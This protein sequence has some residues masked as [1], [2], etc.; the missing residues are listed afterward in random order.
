M[1]KYEFTSKSLKQLRKL[2][3]NIQFKIINKLDE[4]CSHE[5]LSANANIEHLTNFKIGEYRTRIGNYRIIFDLENDT[6]V[7]LKVGHRKDVY[8]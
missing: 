5:K 4:I 2:D 1:F 3:R 8:K 6:L 7:I